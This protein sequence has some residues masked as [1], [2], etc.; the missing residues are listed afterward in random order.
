ML[1]LTGHRSV[2]FK[3]SKRL[4][5]NCHS[6]KEKWTIFGRC[7]EPIGQRFIA[8]P[9]LAEQHHLLLL[10]SVAVVGRRRRCSLCVLNGS[11]CEKTQIKQTFKVTLSKGTSREPTT[12]T[13][14]GRW[15]R[16]AFWSRRCH[17]RRVVK[18]VVTDHC[19][20]SS[21]SVQIADNSIQ[22]LQSRPIW[23]IRLLW[24]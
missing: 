8:R 16:F 23:W 12:T 19:S 5:A 21:P 7:T 22:F 10:L 4:S 3:L 20:T 1:M 2:H 11:T 24:D 15:R 9:D 6:W 18:S 14:T 17:R 13:M